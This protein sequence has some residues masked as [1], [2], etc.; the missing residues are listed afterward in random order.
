MFWEPQ[1]Q[2]TR[3]KTVRRFRLSACLTSVSPLHFSMQEAET[4]AELCAQRLEPRTLGRAAVRSDAPPL[5]ARPL[6]ALEKRDAQGKKKKWG[7][8]LPFLFD[9]LRLFLFSLH[10]TWPLWA[11][12]AR[13]LFPSTDAI[14][15]AFGATRRKNL[16]SA[17]RLSFV[18]VSL[19]PLRSLITRRPRVWRRLGL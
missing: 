19:E 16:D 2:P 12:D 8:V 10:L 14:S 13:L 18:L 1:L 6:L 11:P 15:A 4:A 7:K 17:A 9:R 5:C 3:G